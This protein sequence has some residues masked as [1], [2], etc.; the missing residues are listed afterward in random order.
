[1]GLLLFIEA[2]PLRTFKYRADGESATRVQLRNGPESKT[3]K[4]MYV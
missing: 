4:E 1:M 2:A 3:G